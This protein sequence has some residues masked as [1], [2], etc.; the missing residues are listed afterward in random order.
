MQ[1][2]SNNIG[3]GNSIK[4]AVKTAAENGSGIDLQGLKKQLL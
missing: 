3:L 4:N 2:L 1:D